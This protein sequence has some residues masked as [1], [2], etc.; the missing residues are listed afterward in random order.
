MLFL[1]YF[2]TFFNMA[3]SNIENSEKLDIIKIAIIDNE[4]FKTNEMMK[5][6]FQTL[7]DEENE[8]R[9]FQTT[10]VEKE[11]EA[12]ELLQKGE[13]EGYLRLEKDESNVIFQSNGIGQTILKQV[14]EEIMQNRE[15]VNQLLQ[16][17]IQKG[18]LDYQKN[19]QEI[20]QKIQQESV[21][22]KNS[23]KDNI[24]Y[25]MVE[26]YTLIAMTCLYG[27]LL[28][29]VAINQ[30]LPNMSDNGKRVSVAPTSKGKVVLSSVFAGYVAQ[31]VGL[32]I[33]FIYTIFVL[34]VDYGSNLPL[35]FLL[36]MIGSFAGLSMGIAIGS[37]LKAKESIKTGILI[38]VTMLGC[39]LSGMMGVTM[40]YTIDKNIPIINKINPASMITDGF[41]SLYY[42]D[43]L[44]R[45]YFNIISLVVFTL[46]MI[47]ISYTCL[48]R[49]KYDSI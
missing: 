9:I 48:R 13:I 4:T 27:G 45:Y 37:V 15:I 17:K 7:S 41:Y 8:D 49:Q 6:T 36:G 10:Y 38:S 20:L 28:G 30:N 23:S 2:G 19:I 25:T 12:K 47:A 44:D 32:V 5:E 21:E 39:F 34:K 11:E 14:T 22:I 43:T 46:I 33:L 3:F 18:E 35:I 26:F 1:L 29:M 31:M 16:N 24:S 40:K 42:Y